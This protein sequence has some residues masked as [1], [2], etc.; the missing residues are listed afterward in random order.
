ML[1]TITKIEPKSNDWKIV[2]GTGADGSFL[3]DASVN[4][5]NKKGEVFPNFDGITEGAQIEGEP[6]KSDSGKWYLFAPRAHRPKGRQNFDVAATMA[7]KD[8]SIEKFT[9]KKEY[10][11]KVSST[12]RDATLI[13]TALMHTDSQ[14]AEFVD[15][16]KQWLS[17][18][19]WLWDNFDKEPDLPSQY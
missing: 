4:R 15:W 13:L 3:I 18:R 7:R 19:Q 6:W 12:A 2:G 17:I 8:A 1:Y 14:L 11:I 16:Q 5:V 10:A 9:D